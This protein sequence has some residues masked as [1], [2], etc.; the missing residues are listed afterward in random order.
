VAT[1]DNN[2]YQGE[3]GVLLELSHPTGDA[4][5]GTPPVARVNILDNE[6][7]DA[8][9]LDDFETPPYLW[10][11]GNQATLSN[12]EIA[13]GD[14]R[15]LPGQGAYEHVLQANRLHGNGT[16]EFGRTFPIGQD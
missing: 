5:L 9:L 15:A 2:K 16:Y 14:P 3:R 12:P 4:A 1:F 6:S 8:S 13:A 10:A 7:Y 11:A